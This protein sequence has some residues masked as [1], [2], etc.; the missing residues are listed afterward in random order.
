MTDGQ[1]RAIILDMDGLM[2]DTEPI[3]KRALQQAATEFGQVLEDDFYVTLIGKPQ[4]ACEVAISEKFGSHFPMESYRQRWEGLWREDAEGSGIAKKPGLDAFLAFLTER[5]IRHAVA[6]S[7]DAEYACFS[8][9]AAGL[10]G[11]F[12]TMVTGNEVVNGKPAPDIYIEAARRLGVPPTSCM[13][14]EDSDN[15]VLSASAAGMRTVMVPD[16]K[17]PSDE[18]RAAASRIVG[19]LHEARE[20]LASAFN[21]LPASKRGR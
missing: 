16:M 19:S 3:Y 20:L 15:G 14:L 5:G 13:A 17:E 18:A 21:H 9:E 6:T 2:I 12:G 10:G 4:P 7:S 11:R 1:I 8:L